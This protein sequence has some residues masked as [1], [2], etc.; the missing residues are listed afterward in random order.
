[1]KF[2]AILLAGLLALAAPADAAPAKARPKAATAAPPRVVL[3]TD[4]VPERYDISIATS[5]KDLSFSGHETILV[6]VKRP[7][8][9]ITLNAADISFIKVRLSC[10][11]EAPLVVLD[12]AKQ[13]HAFVKDRGGCAQFRATWLATNP[14]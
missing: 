5:A 4:V 10:S 14:Q 12:K 2:F 3:P 6:S 8:R 13:I 1:M 7:T 11:P 9:S